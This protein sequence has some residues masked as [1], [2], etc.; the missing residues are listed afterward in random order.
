MTEKEPDVTKEDQGY[1]NEFSRLYT[2]NKLV[3]K[4]L[5]ELKEK[6][7]SLVDA[8]QAIEESFGSTIKLTI[9]ETFFEADE[10][11]AKAYIGKLRKKYNNRQKEAKD[12]F[13]TTKK[14]LDELKIILYGKFGARLRLKKDKIKNNLYI[15]KLN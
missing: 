8:E 13:D 7:E 4:E 5:K 3:D 11:K 2:K 9:G 14:R 1:I 15:K 6:L 10:D 12:I